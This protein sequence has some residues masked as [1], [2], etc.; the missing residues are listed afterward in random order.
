MS[1]DLTSPLALIVD[2]EAALRELAAITLERMGIACVCV[3]DL[4]SARAALGA[5]EFDFCLTDMR[6]PDGSGL[7]LI[8]D[9]QQQFPQLPVAMI[10]AHGNMESA[11]EALKAGAFDF[12]NKPVDIQALRGLATQALRTA[13]H[14]GRGDA[15]RQLIGVSPAI[16]RLRELVGKLARSQAPVYISG[17]SGTGKELVARLIHEQGP[18]A[19]HPFV[20]VNCG[21]LP[22]ELVESELFGHRKGSF[23]GALADKPGLF[24]AAEGGTLFLDEVGDLP[25]AMQVKLLRA[26]QERRVRP[27]GSPVEESVDCR[28]LSATHQPLQGLVASGKFRQ[29]LY[30]RINV[31]E[32]HV[33]A[34]R[35]RGEDLRPLVQ[36]ILAQGV[37]G[38]A[39]TLSEA[40]WQALST[41]A[42]PGN[43][44]ELENILARAVA[45][46]EGEV[47]DVGDLHLQAAEPANPLPDALDATDPPSMR[48]D[49]DAERSRLLDALT[50]TRWNRTRAAAQ[51]GISLRAL[52]YRLQ[53]FGLDE[54]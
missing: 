12:V 24:Q 37:E 41:Y 39:P 20:P 38:T 45:L 8:A 31:I 25:L 51:L 29:D 3:P 27:V 36:H 21:A 15:S 33:P 32:V 54:G 47:L 22:P 26:V 2:D 42:F 16:Q 44:R 10:T 46:A 28:I 9:I 1:R 48:A 11:I 13:R 18:R 6:L 5:R 50:R 43:V 19:A 17:E 49:A 4:A 35:E 53:K 14:K 40:A 23:T 52:R 7:T 34:L 30:Y